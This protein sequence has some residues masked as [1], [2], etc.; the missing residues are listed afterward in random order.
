[1]IDQLIRKLARIQE[2]FSSMPQEMQHA[3]IR[4]AYSEIMAYGLSNV[5]VDGTR[6]HR[7]GTEVSDLQAFVM[8]QAEMEG[9]E[10]A[11]DHYCAIGEAAKTSCDFVKKLWHEERGKIF[12][13]NNADELKSHNAAL[14][15]ILLTCFPDDAIDNT[16]IL[17]GFY[18]PLEEALSLLNIPEKKSEFTIALRSVRKIIEAEPFKDSDRHV[19]LRRLAYDGSISSN[20]E[21][22]KA[23]VESLNIL[24]GLNEPDSGRLKSLI[25]KMDLNPSYISQHMLYDLYYQLRDIHIHLESEGNFLY[26]DD[27]LPSAVACHQTF[28]EFLIRHGHNQDVFFLSLITNQPMSA[29]QSISE[30]Y[31]GDPRFAVRELIAL[32]EE[33]KWSPL[34]TDKVILPSTW[35]KSL[36]IDDLLSL[37]ITDDTHWLIL[38]EICG[39][40]G[41]VQK[42]KTKH[43]RDHALST[44]LGL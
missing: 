15:F 24:V 16:E 35:I 11:F 31:P 37:K 9:P 22:A 44:D 42:M 40:K 34:K 3:S 36:P 10:A 4:D 19:L 41:F 28:T 39:G 43:G 32:I 14:G 7:S 18:E 26:E 6:L 1:M 17:E 23:L 21:S 13:F 30:K 33:E 27:L 12:S 2:D 8:S 29:M 25:D 20:E 38:H 5:I